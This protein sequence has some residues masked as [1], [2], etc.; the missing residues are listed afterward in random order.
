MSSELQLPIKP[1][2]ISIRKDPNVTSKGVISLRKTP[3]VSIPPTIRFNTAFQQNQS[4]SATS[5]YEFCRGIMYNWFPPTNF[6]KSPVSGALTINGNNVGNLDFIVVPGQSVTA[7]NLGYWFAQTRDTASSWIFVKGNLNIANDTVLQPPTRKL[8][9]VV[10]VQGN[11]TFGNASSGISMTQ[12][13][14]NHSGIGD[15]GGLTDAVDI[16]IG[17]NTLIAANGG[18]GGALNETSNSATQGTN[19]STAQ[20]GLGTG[21]GGGGWN[22]YLPSS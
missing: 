6:T 2:D 21:G 22:D 19:G 11:L 1:A 3:I 14:A 15:S 9:T 16:S 5:I 12:R 7:L 17:P 20:T 4:Y 13:G 10:Y 18:V 8:F